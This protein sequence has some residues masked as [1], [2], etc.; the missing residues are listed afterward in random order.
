MRRFIP[1]TLLALATA[2]AAA[3]TPGSVQAPNNST[4]GAKVYKQICAACHMPDGSGSGA[5][6]IPALAKNTHLADPAY[7]IGVVV[8]GKG[9]MPPMA[10]IL[11]PGQIAAVL[12]FVR[13]NFGNSYAPPITETD[14]K[15]ASK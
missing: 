10:E 9:A 15:A 12:T 13:S 5:G 2:P 11:K 6:A 1:L 14:V 3:D 7:P 8:R 4:D